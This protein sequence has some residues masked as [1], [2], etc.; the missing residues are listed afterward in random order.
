MSDSKFSGPRL[1]P[2][3][4]FPVEHEGERMILVQ[5]PSG[6]ADGPLIVSM[7]GFFAITLLDGGRSLGD[8]REVFQSR[9]NQE[10]PTEQLEDMVEQLDLAHYLESERFT[11][12]YGT[13]VDAYRAASTRTSRD[14]ESFGADGEGLG[15]MIDRMLGGCRAASAPPA[16]RA[17]VGLVAPHLDYARGGPCYLPAYR[18]L[19]EA[20][21]V[22]RVVILGTNHFGHATSVVA[23]GKAFETPLGTTRTDYDFLS[24]L[25]RRCGA[26]LCEHEFDH[27]REHSVELQLIILQ[28]LLGPETFEIVPVLCPDP[29]GPTGTTPYDGHGVDLRVF[30]EAL[31]E[32]LRADRNGKRTMILAGADLSHFGRRFGDDRDLEPD[33]LAEVERKDREALGA[34]VTGRPDL[35]LDAIKCHNNDTKICS[36]GSIYVLMT[37]LRGARVELLKYHQAVDSESDTAVSCAALAVYAG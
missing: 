6:L 23:T 4:A 16:G 36:V 27:L 28:H 3:E 19:A 12:F 20:G 31:G 21:P 11:E 15:P 10:L 14:A 29:C 5:D 33:F 25:Q 7:A 30:A 34:M 9:F 18:A 24:E 8:I 26:D 1:R 32:C 37:A 17:L 13:L 2:V 35:L 22:Q